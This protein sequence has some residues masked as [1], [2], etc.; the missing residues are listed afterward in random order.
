[1][2][3]QALR[4]RKNE[5]ARAANQLLAEKGEQVWTK[6]DQSAYNKFMEDLDLANGQIQA[7]QTQLDKRAEE[8]FA[9]ARR[10][11]PGAQKNEKTKGLDA[12][13]RKKLQDMTSEEVVAVRNTMSTTTGSQGGYTVETDIASNFVDMLKDYGGMRRV[14]DRV[15]T[16]MGNP[17]S[18]PTTDGRTEVG[19]W[20]AQ[21]TAASA[22]DASF[23][24]A[25]VTC[26]KASSKII[27]V[28]IELLQD[29]QIDVTALVQTRMRDRI[30][31]IMNQGFTTGA[32]D[33][34]SQPFGLATQASVGVTGATGTTLT[35]TFASLIALIESIDYAYQQEGNLRF[36]MS[37]AARKVIRS[38][39]DNNG[40]PIFIPGYGSIGQAVPDT[41]LG[42]ELAINNDMA[43]PAAN[44]KSIS[45]GNHSKFL[46][47]DSLEVTL[48]RLTTART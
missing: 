47:R 16:S 5:I 26:W 3:I 32:G 36:M 7:L 23:G 22:L 29:S 17:M 38:M 33:A 13:L 30:G 43:A 48:F 19:E 18:F 4:E 21:N 25:P 35:V 11:D 39:V 31:R 42:F 1:M 20:V 41:L 24:T 34:S 45:F 44:A 37:Q 40:R 46:I 9:D 6:E 8:T 28:P 27:T 2:S 12:F 10:T 15:V 14:A